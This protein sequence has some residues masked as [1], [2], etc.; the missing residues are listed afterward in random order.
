VKNKNTNINKLTNMKK[1]DMR[2]QS[3]NSKLR[4][5]LHNNWPGPI[6]KAI[7]MRK[8]AKAA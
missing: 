2:K 5:I 4:N 8:E 6:F 1:T 7:D 3:D